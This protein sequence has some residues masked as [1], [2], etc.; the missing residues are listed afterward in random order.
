ML[1]FD[2]LF[3]ARVFL[4]HL[5]AVHHLVQRKRDEL[6]LE[7]LGEIVDRAELDSLDGRLDGP[8]GGHD[9]DSHI[10]VPGTEGP[11]QFQPVHRLHFQIGQHNIE[12][13]LL[14]QPQRLGAAVAAGSLQAIAVNE[15]NEH[16]LHIAI[17]VDHQ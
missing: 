9:D 14:Q 13:L 15:F 12:G 7:W 5:D 2:L 1:A 10:G 3:Q 8:K 11:Q 16:L 6:H 17:I 4:V